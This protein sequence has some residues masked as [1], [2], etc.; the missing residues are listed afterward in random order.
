MRMRRRRQLVID[1]SIAGRGPKANLDFLDA[2]VAICHSA[3]MTPDLRREWKDNGTPA[4]LDW[5]AEMTA[6]RKVLH[7]SAPVD[8]SLREGIGAFPGSEKERR[9]M[10]KDAHLIEA[11]WAADQ[12][13]V[14]NDET[15]RML[16]SR[17]SANLGRL[18][19]VVWINPLEEPRRVEEWL[20]RG[21]APRPEWL[22]GRSE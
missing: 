1:A 20:R 3:V 6:K 9:E 4:S 5:L 11:A 12:A 21:V 18:R 7:P 13:V 14:S 15:A 22:L 16:F 2:V 19:T 8:T 10:L 17:L